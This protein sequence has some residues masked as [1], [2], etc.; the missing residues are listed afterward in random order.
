MWNDGQMEGEQT[1]VLRSPALRS[2]VI[3]TIFLVCVFMGWFQR[4]SFLLQV[5][6]FIN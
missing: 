5:Y 4:S 2:T 6:T 3:D 1:F